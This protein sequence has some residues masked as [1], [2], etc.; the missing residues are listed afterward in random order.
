MPESKA[1][2]IS[3]AIDAVLV[4]ALIGGVKVVTGHNADGTAIVETI[5]PPAAM[6][7][8]AI[9]RL[10]QMGMSKVATPDNPV[11]EAVRRVGAGLRLVGGDLPPLS[12]YP[13]A[14][15]A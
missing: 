13:D 8:A 10:A 2:T 3:D 14:A 15:A 4:A 9:K 11:A 12:D 6:V 5:S 7:T 1:Q